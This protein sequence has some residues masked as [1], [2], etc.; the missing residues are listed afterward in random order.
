MQ[1]LDKIKNEHWFWDTEMLI[2]AQRSKYRIKEIPVK[3]EDKGPKTNV[4]TFHDSFVM[5]CKIVG[6][7]LK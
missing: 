1:F 2:L 5:F 6:M 3:W 7:R 4:K